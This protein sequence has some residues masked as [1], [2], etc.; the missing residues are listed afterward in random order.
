[1]SKGKTSKTLVWILMA[2]LILGLGG[3]GMT[4]L[5]GTI[6]SVGDVG[7]KEI[8]VNDYARALQDEMRALEAQTGQSLPFSQA[9]AFGID[10]VVLARL[11]TTRSM[12]AENDRLGISIGDENLRQE[13]MSIPAFLGLNGDFDRDAYSFAIDQAGM[14]ES[15]FEDSIREETARSLLQGAIVSG[16]TMPDSYADVVIQFVAEERDFTWTLLTADNLT[17]PVDV[18]SDADI[19]T[20]Y[21]ANLDNFMLPATRQ[22]TYAW[23]SPDMII[24]DVEVDEDALRALY[25]E[26]DAEFNRPERRLV[27]RLVF[28]DEA[29]A[30]NAI[31][32]L[33]RGE[34]SF[35]A[36]VEERGL[37]LA[38]VDL[39]DVSKADLGAA[40]EAVF[41]TP[42]GAMS[43]PAKS[44]LGPAIFRVNAVLQAQST[45]F[46]DARTELR[47]ELAAERA[48]RVID[49]QIGT[50]DDLLAA[51]ATLEELAD[52]TDMVLATIDWH[53]GAS[54]DIAGYAAF[55][56]TAA[57]VTQ[58]DFAQIETLDDG[59]IFALQ[60]DGETEAHPAPLGDVRDQAAA[61]LRATR[62][63][64]ALQNLVDRLMPRLA[65]GTDFTSFGFTAYQETDMDRGSFIPG[66][67]ATFIEEVFAMVPGDVRTMSNAQGLFVVRL[68]A[69][70]APATDDPEVT[71]LKASITQQLSAGISQDVFQA[72]AQALQ[73]LYP[74]EINQ[75]ALN[76][77][78][79]QFQ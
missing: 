18:P 61:A 25:G 68:K 33:H 15:D 23:L 2:M 43:G 6:R 12:D 27:E 51:G 20:Y 65:D 10:R 76:A 59:G 57:A 48:R 40:G 52:E 74:A 22:I 30:Q 58:D 75:Q 19:S 41:M 26:R 46:E 24:D 36:L 45:S 77:V 1:M 17:R 14:T 21:H 28:G 73:T 70:R 54:D 79:A 64:E 35:E 34:T 37:A 7:G 71:A 32:R 72:Y 67:P 69:I 38:D 31:D 78:H 39:G 50:I 49:V 4:S 3:F 16:V 60:L 62:T 66:A 44:N 8:S 11:A 63:T 55:R 29:A 47:E 42:A 56:E 53:T 9:Q 13:L 5:S